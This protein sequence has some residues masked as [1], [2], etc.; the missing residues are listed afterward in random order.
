MDCKIE[1]CIQ[2]YFIEEKL[3]EQDFYFD[4]LSFTIRNFDEM[5]EPVSCGS[6]QWYPLVILVS[7]SLANLY[8]PIPCIG[9][10]TLRSIGYVAEYRSFH[11]GVKV[12][13]D[14]GFDFL[15]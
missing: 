5:E 13:R 3:M 2:F 8:R 7:T 14:I 15:I 10:L 6:P 11:C 4:I 9:S 1:N 12:E